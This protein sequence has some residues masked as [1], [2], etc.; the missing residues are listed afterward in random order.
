MND[1]HALSGAYALDAV[2]DVE[3]RE[4]EDHL[5]GCEAC[6]AEVA[7]F[8]ETAAL[9]ATTEAVTPPA[10]LRTD[11]LSAISQVR[12]LPPEPSQTPSPTP[13]DELAV[14]RRR[15]PVILAAA[16]VVLLA[17]GAVIWHPWQQDSSSAVDQVLQASDAVRT[18]QPLEGGGELT[19][20]RSASLDRAVM[21]GKDVPEPASGKTYQLWLQQD[22]KM[23]TAG[24]MPDATKP[25]VLSGDVG[26]ATAAAVS[27]EPDGGS[28]EPTTDPIALFTFTPGS[29]GNGGA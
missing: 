11:V 23:V 15:L 9:V 5:A 12:P 24:L 13:T 8:R 16:A 6:L 4:F 18:T 7:S 28:P 26:T 10:S 1:I 17:V 19:L 14:R 29:S 20:V 2:D 3:R 22:G 21:L 25:T 27:V